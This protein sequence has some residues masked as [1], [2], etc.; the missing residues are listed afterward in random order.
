MTVT[1]WRLLISSRA[2][3]QPTFPAPAITTY[4][5]LHLF[6]RS[7]EHLDGVARRADRVQ[8]LLGVPLGARRVHDAADHARHLVV[9]AGDLRDRQVRVVAVGGGDEHVGLLDA[10]LAQRIDL[11]P[12]AEREAPAGVLPRGVHAR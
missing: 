9:L 10:R 7:L 1:S 11:E 3:F 6:Q 4:M 12:V 8:A 5:P 2:R